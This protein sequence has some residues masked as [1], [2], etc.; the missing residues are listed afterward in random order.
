MSRLR[1]RWFIFAALA[2]WASACL[3]ADLHVLSAKQM[4]PGAV[5]VDVAFAGP[6]LHKAEDFS[7]LLGDAA[8]IKAAELRVLPSS[9]E[10]RALLI[11]IDTSGSM[12]APAVQA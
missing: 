5:A 11:Y 9:T 6:D 10:S 4:R 1:I 2:G 3:A 7:L 8:P 12:G